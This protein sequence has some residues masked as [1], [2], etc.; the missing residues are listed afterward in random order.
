MAHY[1]FVFSVK[2]NGNLRYAD[3][4]EVLDLYDSN[5]RTVAANPSVL[6]LSGQNLLAFPSATSMN[7]EVF[8]LASAALPVNDGDCVLLSREI[9]DAILDYAQHT[10]SWKMGG[11]E[12]QTTMSLFQNII[13]VASKRNAKI[14]AMATFKEV[15][16]G[17]EDREDEIAP[18]ETAKSE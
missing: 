16:Y 5:W 13:K 1:P 9:M 6:G 15:L 11:A 10:A 3:A 18:K 14:L 17:R 4:V 12:F 8:M 7:V 2:V